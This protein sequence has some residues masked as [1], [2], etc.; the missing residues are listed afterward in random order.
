MLTMKKM[1][2]GLTALWLSLSVCQ[3][4]TLQAVPCKDVV[5][6][7]VDVVTENENNFCDPDYIPGSD[8]F[9]TPSA[10]CVPIPCDYALTPERCVVTI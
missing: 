6:L 10:R 3:A 5:P 7:K 4:T 9:L 2:V 1:R 8:E